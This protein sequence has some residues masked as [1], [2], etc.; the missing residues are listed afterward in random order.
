MMTLSSFEDTIKRLL[1]EMNLME[2]IGMSPFE[3]PIN[4]CLTYA[5]PSPCTLVYM[6]WIA[7]C[8]REG[9]KDGRNQEVHLSW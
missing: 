2:G 8:E 4:S 7:E 9:E 5:L 3:S 6:V 1:H